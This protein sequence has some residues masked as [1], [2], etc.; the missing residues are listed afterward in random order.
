MS[1]LYLVLRHRLDVVVDWVPIGTETLRGARKAKGYS[2]ETMGRL[3][4]C[5]A[6]TY[7]RSE[8]EGRVR[9]DMLVRLAEVLDLE[10]E[11]PARRRIDV[12]E[13]SHDVLARL[14]ARLERIETLLEEVR[15]QQVSQVPAVISD[16]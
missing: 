1:D 8:K 9:R 2:Y 7:E 10:I 6:K 4:N 3:L 15:D 5:S 12:P 13:L 16:S 11:Q 14:D